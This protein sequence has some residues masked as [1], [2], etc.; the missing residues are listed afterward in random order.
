[1]LASLKGDRANSTAFAIWAYDELAKADGEAAATAWLRN[2][3]AKDIHE[4]A[5]V[6]FQFGRYD[7][8]WGPLE[9]PARP[10]KEDEIQLMRAASLI[11][12]PDPT[13]ERHEKLVGYFEARPEN[14]WKVMGL[15]LLGKRSEEEIF[16]APKGRFMVCSL[17]WMLGLR[18]A[19]Q[20]R[21]EDASDWFEIA[22]ESDQNQQPP[23]AWAYEILRHWAGQYEP[24]AEIQKKRSLVQKPTPTPSHAG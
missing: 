1:M 5:F 11:Y 19:E 13:G 18:A 9:D 21:Y 12:A 4:L 2:T 24:L 10:T 3:T 20:G 14:D 7:I 15:F 23:D 16:K 6:A 8:L 22:V 17:G